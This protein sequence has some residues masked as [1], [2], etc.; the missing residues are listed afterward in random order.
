M[1]SKMSA[2]LNYLAD[3]MSRFALASDN[4]SALVDVGH[5][6]YDARAVLTVGGAD[7]APVAAEL[8]GLAE[9]ILDAEGVA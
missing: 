7:A 3:R 1:T 6:L 2:R 5:H 4:T 8:L 9:E